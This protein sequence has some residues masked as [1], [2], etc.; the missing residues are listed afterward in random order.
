MSTFSRRMP[1]QLQSQPIMDERAHAQVFPSVPEE[2]KRPNERALA[3]T[4]MTSQFPELL[5]SQK[6]IC[7]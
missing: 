1:Q 7:D 2:P 5:H 4:G 6:R 3:L